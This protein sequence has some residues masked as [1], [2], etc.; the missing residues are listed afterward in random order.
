MRQKPVS[1]PS[2]RH[3]LGGLA[4][5]MTVAP[6]SA[7]TTSGK[8]DVDSVLSQAADA[9]A[10][11]TEA[12]DVARNAEDA[13]RLQTPN[14][15][16]ASQTPDNL[17]TASV[18]ASD[19]AASFQ[20]AVMQPT[21]INA[22]AMSIFANAR[23]AAQPVQV[24]SY[25]PDTGTRSFFAQVYSMPEQAYAAS[26]GLYQSLQIESPKETHPDL[27]TRMAV[28]EDSEED[29]KPR[30]LAR[31]VSLSGMTRIAPNGLAIQT[32]DI[33]VSCFKPELM[34][35]IHNIES[36][37][38]KKVLVTSGYR[39]KERNRRAGGVE[40]S[41]HTHCDAADIQVKGVSNGDLANYVRALPDRGGVGTYCHTK[42]IHIDTGRP[43]DWNWTCDVASRK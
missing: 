39:D 10:T 14:L 33:D 30:G 9:D 26:P 2:R 34:G 28:D 40:G 11:E 22:S 16:E 43:R 24:A 18:P 15:A 3:L 35:M 20:N 6:L 36:H 5:L 13:K 29:E 8:A 42:S 31:L 21:A 1:I 27:S 37:F 38:G 23:S 12:T 32:P 17:Q 19:P 4:I 25:A 41:L 7:C